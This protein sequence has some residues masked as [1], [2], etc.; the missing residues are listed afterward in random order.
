MWDG[1]KE[2]LNLIHNLTAAKQAN[3]ARNATLTL[4][5]P[6]KSFIAVARKKISW[7]EHALF[8]I[9]TLKGAVWPPSRSSITA[10]STQ[11]DVKPRHCENEG[12]NDRKQRHSLQGYDPVS[13]VKK[14]GRPGAR[15]R[16]RKQVESSR[17]ALVA[18]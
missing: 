7:K 15:N 5:V 12:R 10:I 18:K 4:S 9:E 16:T 3:V 1:R 8:L 13:Y 6:T 17:A 14:R 11:T 2:T